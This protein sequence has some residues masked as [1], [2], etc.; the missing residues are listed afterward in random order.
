M[1][2]DVFGDWDNLSDELRSD[3]FDKPCDLFGELSDNSSVKRTD[4]QRRRNI[5][6]L[7][8]NWCT[9]PL[10]F[11]NRRDCSSDEESVTYANSV[12]CSS[13]DESDTH[14]IS[15]DGSDCSSDDESGT[16]AIP[17]TLP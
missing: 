1:M 11:A 3:S 13:D 9:L 6:A 5:Q 10:T 8:E 2:K 7:R 14:T 12:G 15:V 17:E 4:T 16:H